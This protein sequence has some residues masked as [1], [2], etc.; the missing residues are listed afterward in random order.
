MT[1]GLPG[2]CHRS[3]DWWQAE[4][5]SQRRDTPAPHSASAGLTCSKNTLYCWFL[6][7]RGSS[8]PPPGRYM[9]TEVEEGAWGITAKSYL[10]CHPAFPSGM[11]RAG[12]GRSPL[13]GVKIKRSRRGS[14]RSQLGERGKA[15]RGQKP[16][17]T[18]LQLHATARGSGICLRAHPPG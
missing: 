5:G 12:E 15:E 7:W 1:Q 10:C 4:A 16:A 18:S 11:E 17:C 9:V 2:R 8:G 13:P 3:S 6:G 14:S